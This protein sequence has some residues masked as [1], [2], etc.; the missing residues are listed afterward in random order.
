L[1][2]VKCIPI[3]SEDV[4]VPVNRNVTCLYLVLDSQYPYS[5]HLLYSPKGKNLIG[6]RVCIATPRY[7]FVN[8]TEVKEYGVYRLKLRRDRIRPPIAILEISGS[9]GGEV[10]IVLPPNSAKELRLDLDGEAYYAYLTEI[11][12]LSPFKPLFKISSSL[13]VIRSK[14]LRKVELGREV[15][16][17]DEVVNLTLFDNS[18]TL[19]NEG[20]WPL[21]V[22]IKV[23]RVKLKPVLSLN[24][25]SN[26][27]IGNEKCYLMLNLPNYLALRGYKGIWSYDPLTGLP[28]PFKPIF[29][30]LNEIASREL[31]LVRLKLKLSVPR[32]GINPSTEVYVE[33]PWSVREGPIYL[34][35]GIIKEVGT[36]PSYA[37]PVKLIVNGSS[38]M[39]YNITGSCIDGSVILPLTTYNLTVGLNTVN[40]KPFEN[41]EVTIKVYSHERNNYVIVK[42]GYSGPFTCKLLPGNYSLIVE[43]GGLIVANK[44]FDLKEDSHL[45]LRCNLTYVRLTLRPIKG[46][47]VEGLKVKLRAGNLTRVGIV[48]EGGS[49]NLGLLPLTTYFVRVEGR[50]GLI[51]YEGSLKPHVRTIPIAISYLTVHI[52]DLLGRPLRGVRISLIKGV[53]EVSSVTDEYGYANLTSIPSGNYELKVNWGKTVLA[54]KYLYLKGGYEFL[55]LRTGVISFVA[56]IPLTLREFILGIALFCVTSIAIITKIKLGKEELEVVK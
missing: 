13:Y 56:G 12:V 22:L 27:S 53:K 34:P 38:V 49:V 32:D 52:S 15:N 19:I 47:V 5:P 9:T 30:K 33:I 50:G 17:L 7:V 16:L 26:V 46:G 23:R 11:H 44:Y 48:D 31:K 20:R 43:F 8:L 29:L 14:K 41:G 45:N 24:D 42:K 4:K 25:L 2:S 21:S 3:T 6:S 37:F 28:I 40:G 18:L 35:V 1:I 10:S 51:I 54:H 55:E 39:Y 36:V